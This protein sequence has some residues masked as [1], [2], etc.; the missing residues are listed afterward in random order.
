M[1]CSQP[2][3]FFKQGVKRNSESIMRL[4]WDETCIDIRFYRI[5]NDIISFYAQGNLWGAIRPETK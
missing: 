4:Y 3:A 1:L 2:A 5:Y